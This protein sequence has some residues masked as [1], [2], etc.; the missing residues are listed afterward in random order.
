[1]SGISQTQA[2]GGIV[3]AIV[4][5]TWWTLSICKEIKKL[6]RAADD[7]SL[8]N[9]GSLTD[10]S[11]PIKNELLVLAEKVAICCLGHV[12]PAALLPENRGLHR[13]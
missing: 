11:S 10:K 13:S 2:F 12:H 8:L 4:L 7:K 3:A 5:S 9:E 6:K 1:M